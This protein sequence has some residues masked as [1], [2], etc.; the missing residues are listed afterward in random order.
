MAKCAKDKHSLNI[1]L[2]DIET[3]P[4]EALTWGTFKQTVGVEQIKTEWSVISF[5]AKWLGEKKVIYRDTGGRGKRQVRNDKA[6]MLE[7]HELLDKA[8]I[9]IG[10]NVRRFDVKKVNARMLMHGIPPYSPIQVIDTLQVAR[11]HFALTS[12][13]LAWASK[14]LTDSPKLLHREFPGFELWL[15]CLRD[16]PKA[17]RVMRKYNKR[18]VI[19]L[20]KYYYRLRPWIDNHPM[21]KPYKGRCPNC[22]SND[23]RPY[24]HRYT[25]FYKTQRHKCNECNSW[26]TGTRTKI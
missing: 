10:H 6:L 23:Y 11:K 25:R 4:I 22:G 1:L 14:H 20:E 5:A 17:W 15:E 18:D 12:N 26:F 19:A 2:L 7:L 21:V 8:D 16:N 24:G 3:V 13:K 9:V